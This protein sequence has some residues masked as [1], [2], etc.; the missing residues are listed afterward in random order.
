M[1]LR[2]STSLSAF[3]APR[4]KQRA[5]G[6]GRQRT[7]ALCDAPATAMVEKATLNHAAAPLDGAGGLPVPLCATHLGA[8]NQAQIAAVAETAN[9]NGVLEKDAVWNRPTWPADNRT[10]RRAHAFDTATERASDGT[11]AKNGWHRWEKYRG[12]EGGKPPHS[13]SAKETQALGVLGL[14]G[15]A[16]PAQ[17]RRRYRRLVKTLHPDAP[18]APSPQRAEQEEQLRAVECGLARTQTPAGKQE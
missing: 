11:T 18:Q 5:G 15:A 4:P 17:I 9:W 2:S 8:H 7:C 6:S 1:P 14:D 13:L 10:A 3:F 12:K 16:S